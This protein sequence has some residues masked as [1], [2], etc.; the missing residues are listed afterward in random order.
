MLI[1]RE[2]QN[3]SRYKL[4]NFGQK[5]S[6]E[7]PEGYSES[8]FWWIEIVNVISFE[9]FAGSLFDILC[10]W[11]IRDWIGDTLIILIYYFNN[12]LII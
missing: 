3:Y 10:N 11:R 5:K 8:P 12:I 2:P 4:E 1:T 6:I 7:E 9:G